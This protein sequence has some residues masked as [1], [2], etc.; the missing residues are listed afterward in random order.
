MI[1]ALAASILSVALGAILG[2]VRG[3]MERTVGP[4]RTFAVVAAVAVA[5]STLMP[6][7][8]AALGMWAFVVL[9][10][11]FALPAVIERIMV[12][13]HDH[14]VEQ[15]RH[16]I[17][18]DVSFIGLLIHQIGDGVGQGIYGAPTPPNEAH[19]DVVLAI[20]VHSI[21]VAAFVVL[22]YRARVGSAVAVQRAV[23]LG[24]AGAAGVLMTRL[25]PSQTLQSWEPWTAAAVAGL[26]LHV[27]THGW[28]LE[29]IRTTTGRVLDLGAVIA[30]G[31]VVFLGHDSHGGA[32]GGPDLRGATFHAL[33]DL[34]LETAPILLI[35]LVIASFLQLW[36][37][38]VPAR[39]HGARTHWGQALQGAAVG[40]PL[41]ICACGVLPIAQMLSRRGAPAAFVIAFLIATPEL[42]V[43]TFVL[44]F[45]FLGWRFALL[46]IVAALLLAIVAA[47][48]V[49][50]VSPPSAHSALP[51]AALT[52]EGSG[53]WPS[54]ALHVLDDLLQHVGPWTF[55]GL[56]AAA[57]TQAALP[58]GEL[59]GL[60]ETGLDVLI[61]SVIAIPSY[62]CA[63]S[64][65]P[66][67]AILMA[68]GLSP[69]AALVGLLLGPATNI[70]TVGWM[71]AH[72]GTRAAIWGI[73]GLLVAA[74]A[75][76][77]LVNA[78]PWLWPVML[79]PTG[80]T[81]EHGWP[82]IAAT[83]ALF[84]LVL[85]GIWRSGLRAWVDSLG[86]AL[87]HGG[88]NHSHGH[89]HHGHSHHH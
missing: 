8:L 43:D 67:A 55:L 26:L 79:P 1:L 11:A 13:G 89:E 68:K 35:G 29:P 7:S 24:V 17:G 66:L 37:S 15:R 30:G 81:H 48:L 62:V 49:A 71:R 78:T 18:L 44:S 41:P 65:T 85:R 22:A 34:A 86:Q 51:G 53:P 64:A 38:K 42:G 10:V 52:E 87:S 84:A 69:G 77:A 20:A 88:S 58:P 61:V 2:F 16:R 46:R 6:E 14:H 74:W 57:Y 4:V 59:L 83:V 19:P 70:A 40:A 5:L 3:P 76:A 82:S 32:E 33:I 27:V 9:G 45:Q 39:M 47:I 60:A 73:G 25:V 21:P 31:A 72:F 50:R 12:R 54:R 75:I 28:P 23:A 36:G 56:I 63:S 80:Q